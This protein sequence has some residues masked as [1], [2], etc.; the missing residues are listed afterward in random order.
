M[1]DVS[2]AWSSPTYANG[3]WTSAIEVDTGVDLVQPGDEMR[4]TFALL[5]DRRLTEQVNPAAGGAPK[6]IVYDEGLLFGGTCT[7]TAL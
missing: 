3:I 4:F 1:V 2:D 6:P 7:V 5:L